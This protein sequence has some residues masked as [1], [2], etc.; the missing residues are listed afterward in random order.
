MSEYDVTRI[1]LNAQQQAAL[2]HQPLTQAATDI[3][4][5]LRKAGYSAFFAGGSVRDLLLGREFHDV[6]IATQATPDQ[7]QKCFSRVTDLQG[8]AFGVVRV[9]E[10]GFTF[11]IATF[12][13]DGDYHDGRRPDSVRFTTADEDASRRD[14][15]VNGLF[16]DPLGMEVLDY[17]GGI[18]DLGAGIIRAI[19]D[20]Q[21]RFREDQ[22]RLFRAV[23][24]AAEFSFQ[25]EGATWSALQEN[26]AASKTLVPERVREELIKIFT[27]SD[28]EKGFDLLMD[29]G[30]M[31]I[32]IPEVGKMKG[33]E[34][35]PQFHPEGDVYTHVRMMLGMLKKA[36]LILAF[37]TLFH[38]IAKPKTYK[39]DPTGRIRF[40]E[41]EVKGAHMAEEIMKRLRFSNDEIEGVSQCVKNHMSFKDVPKMKLSTLKR[42]LARD[43][44]EAELE[45]HR[46]DCTCSHGKLDIHAFLQEKKNEFPQEVI[47]PKPFLNGNDL[48]E[49]G[50]LPGPKLGKTLRK[51]EDLQLEGILSNREE[52][53]AKAKEFLKQA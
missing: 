51:L 19:G 32:W 34:Q 21:Q 24:F 26:A 9:I 13:E 23:R 8:K 17:V 48:M 47:K 31:D 14:F 20:P 43:H 30:L 12:R 27:G 33:V 1:G 39:V 2:N 44:F 42:F 6:D 40:N 22:L 45:L 5:T 15:T 18:K 35:P 36:D 3:V 16:Y 53:L 29:S 37:S 41:H 52:A 7:V 25:I 50:M 49:L 28:P 11:E 38:D 10:K 4:K 46:L